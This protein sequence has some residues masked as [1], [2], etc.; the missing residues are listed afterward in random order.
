MNTRRSRP[1]SSM[2]TGNEAP[3]NPACLTALRKAWIEPEC[4]LEGRRT[5]GPTRT[6]W[7][8]FAIPPSSCCSVTP[9]LLQTNGSAARRPVTTACAHRRDPTSGEVAP[10]DRAGVRHFVRQRCGPPHQ[11]QA[12]LTDARYWTVPAPPTRRS[13]RV[14][15]QAWT[16][17]G[18]RLEIAMCSCRALTIPA[19]G[20]FGVRW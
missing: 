10:S 11:L 5:C 2:P 9:P 18:A 19:R 4:G 6:T 7:P 8:A 17:R 13:K 16:L 15:V 12:R 1:S 3:S 14:E 20:V